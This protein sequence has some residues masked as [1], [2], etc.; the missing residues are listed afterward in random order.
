MSSPT[1]ETFEASEAMWLRLFPASLARHHGLIAQKLTLT[2]AADIRLGQDFNMLLAPDLLWLTER[3]A[4]GSP[5]PSPR[6]EPPLSP[7]ALDAKAHALRQE[8]K[9]QKRLGHSYL[10]DCVL[11]DLQHGV[12]LNA[13]LFAV[14]KKLTLLCAIALTR[15]N[16]REQITEDCSIDA[17]LRNVRLAADQRRGPLLTFLSRQDLTLPLETLISSIE[18]QRPE[19]ANNKTLTGQVDTLLRVLDRLAAERLKRE[20]TG[21]GTHRRVQKYQLEFSPLT[22]A[23]DQFQITRLS[24]MLTHQDKRSLSAEERDALRDAHSERQT[25]LIEQRGAET[26]TGIIDPEQALPLMDWQARAQQS[27]SVALSMSLRAQLLP[28]DPGCA[29]PHHITALVQGVNRVSHPTVAQ[30]ALLAM[31]V[32][33]LDWPA[34]KALPLWCAPPHQV[35][36]PG[37]SYRGHDQ[38]FQTTGIWC[39]DG[40]F[41]LQR[42]H[43]VAHSQV[44]QKLDPLLL[45]VAPFIQLPLP[46]ALR[47]LVDDGCLQPCTL[48]QLQQALAQ[49]CSRYQLTLT[50]AQLG[51]YQAQWLQRA[52]VDQAVSG[53]LRGKAAQQCAPLAYSHL[54]GASILAV[55]YDYLGHLGL[56][57]PANA[58]ACDSALGSRLLPRTEALQP[59]LA[60]YQHYLSDP[61][62]VKQRRQHDPHYHNTLVRH[63]LLILN[64]ATGARPVTDIYGMRN[65]YDSRMGLIHLVDKEGRDTVS[66]ARLVP[67]APQALTQL[68]WMVKHLAQ[69]ATRREPA[70]QEAASAAR[71]ALDS[72]RPLLFWLAPAQR[73]DGARQWEVRPITVLSMS[74]AFDTL[75]PLPANW[76]R[77]ALRS[78]LLARQIP[79]HLID[80]LLGHEEMGQEFGHPFSGADL[81][82][83]RALGTQIGDWLDEL[84]LVPLSGWS[85][86]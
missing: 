72:Q 57:S 37:K 18:D 15:L 69:L 84:G 32:F 53:V 46:A 43:Q 24:A 82:S 66:S 65:S 16:L 68:E 11:A 48:T 77:H 22:L 8:L 41:S 19:F 23:D 74:D 50:V 39:Y 9:Q 17:A 34:I 81:N 83:L 61:S 26:V 64:L 40:Q 7:A 13:E 85:A 33:G 63:T 1:D 70:L 29:L 42:W 56:D 35:P 38:C 20:R 2:L 76:H 79:A 86:R 47:P 73:E 78:Q 55:W 36:A 10:V 14:F 12:T 62:V 31:L 3:L 67:L 25:W 27:R 45:P 60:T 44:H 5:G 6:G 28:C 51:R 54:S 49:L 52:R 21:G 75:L 80:A 58:P 4:T 30:R 59:L 71:A